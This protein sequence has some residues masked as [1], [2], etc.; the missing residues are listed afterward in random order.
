MSN[1]LRKAECCMNCKYYEEDFRHD[2]W[3]KIGMPIRDKRS[4]C[5]AFKLGVY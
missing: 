2:F 5:D 1:N 4:I 3:C